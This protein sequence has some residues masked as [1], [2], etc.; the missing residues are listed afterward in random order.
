MKTFSTTAGRDPAGPSNRRQPVRQTRT[1]PLRASTTVQAST[2]VNLRPQEDIEPTTP[3]FYPALTHFTDA[4]TALPKEM[5][6]HYTMLKEVDAKIYGPE[7][8]LGQLFT[9]ALK[10]PTPRFGQGPPVRGMSHFTRIATTMLS[11]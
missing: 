5:V 3:R 2:A 10:M 9:T 1:N 4:I 8:L 6:R 11:D 7:E